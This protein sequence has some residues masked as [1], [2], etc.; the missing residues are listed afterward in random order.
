MNICFVISE[1]VNP[2]TGGIQRVF[3]NLYNEF[4]KRNYHCIIISKDSPINDEFIE[5][6]K[7]ILPKKTGIVCEENIAFISNIIKREN[8]NYII[9]GGLDDNLFDLCLKVRELNFSLKIIYTEHG[10]PDS[11]LKAIK[12]KYLLP[13]GDGNFIKKA[14][15]FCLTLMHYFYRKVSPSKNVINSFRYRYENSDAFV[16]LSESFKEI[17]CKITKI[18]NVDKLYA[19]H[20][21]IPA[22]IK[23]EENYTKKNQI[24]FVGR[25]V[26][27]VKRPDR[28][29]KIWHKLHRKYPEWKL[30][31]IGDGS[32]KDSL[33]SF[34]EKN[35]INNIVFTGNTDPEKY[36]KESKIICITSTLEG[37][38]MVLLEAQQYGCVAVAYDTYT[39]LRDII[40]NG[41][42]GFIVKPFNHYKYAECLTRLMSN[43]QLLNQMS[44]AAIIEN[45]KF[46]AATIV[47]QWECLFSKLHINE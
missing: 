6:Y 30:V 5:D 33:I 39:S 12:D 35:K 7:H 17:F 13:I 40:T 42:N 46:S 36:Y 23:T 37:L 31:M 1:Y 16:L 15:Y 45:Q 2:Q 22:S 18:T 47:K 38:S 28:L 19:I 20:N 32:S 43:A 21:H 4:S 11:K 10:T 34:C 8:I 26:L 41:K 29:I 44:D 24:I 27:Q 9:Y 14:F 3:Y 25:M